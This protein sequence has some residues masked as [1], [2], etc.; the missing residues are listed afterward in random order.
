MSRLFFAYSGVKRTV[1]FFLENNK[2]RFLRFSFLALVLLASAVPFQA[3][4]ASYTSNSPVNDT[5]RWIACPAEVLSRTQEN[6][7][8]DREYTLRC[9][10]GDTE[11]QQL[12]ARSCLTSGA[13]LFS[14]SEN[15]GRTWT[16]SASFIATAPI[17][18]D[19]ETG[20]PK[21]R[22]SVSES[23]ISDEAPVARPDAQNETAGSRQGL[24][25]Q[26]FGGTAN[27][28]TGVLLEAVAIIIWFF[29]EIFVWM[30]TAILAIVGVFFD[31]I[32]REFVIEMGKYITASN[33]DGVRVAWVVVRDLANIGII[34]GLIATAI[35]TI[36]G[37]G[38]YS[39]SKTLARL[40][41]AALLV[42]FSYFFAGAIIDFSNFTAKAAYQ[43]LIY[44]PGCEE[45]GSC[46]IA[47]RVA[48]IINIPFITEVARRDAQSATTIRENT[49]GERSGTVRVNNRS[50]DT[51]GAFSPSRQATYNVL[52]I[53]FIGITI[54]VFLSAVSLLIARFVALIFLLITSPI[55]IAGGAVPL[56]KSYADEWWKAMW[57]Q[58]MFAPVY[59]VLAGISFKV[60]DSFRGQLSSQQT[61]ET[62][63]F[64]LT[65][66]LEQ[67]IPVAALF[68]V[69]VGFMWVALSTA[70]KMSEETGRFKDLYGGVQ[71]YMT[72]PALGGARMFAAGTLGWA[73]EAT[74]DRYNQFMGADL[75]GKG[76]R[77]FLAKSAQGLLKRSPLGRAG[78]LVL[79]GVASSKF[80]GKKV[81]SFIEGRDR[82]RARQGELNTINE[83]EHAIN[84]VK[85]DSKE[86]EKAFSDYAN[87]TD[88]KAKEEKYQKYLAA[89]AN[90]EKN[91]ADL[92][93]EAFEQLKK[94]DPRALI[95]LAPFMS[96]ATLKRL[97][98]DKEIPKTI[99]NALKDER[100][101]DV[102]ALLQQGN[103]KKIKVDEKGMPIH[104]PNGGYV[105]EE[106]GTAAVKGTK[107]YADL[108]QK[109]FNHFKYSGMKAEDVVGLMQ[110]H[111]DSL[112]LATSSLLLDGGMTNGAKMAILDSTEIPDAQKEI[113][114]RVWQKGNA[115]AVGYTDGSPLHG[116]PVL[117]LD[118]SDQSSWNR[119]AN[120]PTTEINAAIALQTQDASGNVVET[121]FAKAVKTMVKFNL[122]KQGHEF[123]AQ[124]HEDLL[125]SP[126]FAASATVDSIL[127]LEGKKDPPYINTFVDNFVALA[128]SDYI[129]DNPEALARYA[130]ILNHMTNTSKGKN[131]YEARLTAS[132]IRAG[133]DVDT[134]KIRLGQKK[135]TP[136]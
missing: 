129:K 66:S 90:I 39:V 26:I 47:G 65:Q 42:N 60:L 133:I 85:K 109:L 118:P 7:S 8:A 120:M 45:N 124:T 113:I 70:K 43:D 89:K 28:L 72:G 136:A 134:L 110:H 125:L 52:L 121:D 44:Q 36:V 1:V 23:E 32:V 9:R 76:V 128:Q 91:F 4:A 111:H 10:A 100:M 53:V 67:M 41:L 15:G 31:F 16:L 20:A 14:T 117:Y 102:V 112:D 12:W 51:A 38:N 50:R 103:G 84:A 5:A 19:T 22:A 114:K 27:F 131:D 13:C 98:H 25:A 77:G 104:N 35:G 64:G 49:A 68:T 3:D 96:S 86:M 127:D 130:G 62:G 40:I 107:A 54:F 94:R 74:L 82:K 30:L 108:Q 122:G 58:T 11:Y 88:E 34:A 6:V 101:K 81:E 93:E 73:A 115:D 56:L 17:V 18:Y 21:P 63:Q 119:F 33:A 75:K 87:E 92:P 46:G 61:F 116:K 95:R 78:E 132:C 123:A 55:G 79:K 135:P 80:G 69:V 106:T 29:S 99:R 48:E 2:T 37:V 59:F 105:Y 57:S 71:K 83:R 126:V 24:F 97:S